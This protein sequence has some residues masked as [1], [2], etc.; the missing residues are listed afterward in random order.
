MGDFMVFYFSGTGNSLY[1]AKRIAKT[2]NEELVSIA[3]LLTREKEIYEYQLKENEVIGFV[4]P[5]YAWSPPKQVLEFVEKLKLSNYKN[6]YIFS[7]ATCEKISV[8]L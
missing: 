2:N 8:M 5:I 7:I 3:S 1:V 4:Y 6:N